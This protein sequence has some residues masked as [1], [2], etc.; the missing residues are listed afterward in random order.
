MRPSIIDFWPSVS[1]LD[2]QEPIELPLRMLPL[3]HRVLDVQ[4]VGVARLGG[5]QNAL[6]IVVAGAQVHLDRND[7]LHRNE[8]VVAVAVEVD[9]LRPL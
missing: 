9:H 5:L 7:S 8:I 4:T 3:E 2:Q 6:K 1:A